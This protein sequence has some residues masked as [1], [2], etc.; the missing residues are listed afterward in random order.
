MKIIDISENYSKS[1]LDCKKCPEYLCKVYQERILNEQRFY[2]LASRDFTLF[3]PCRVINAECKGNT[4]DEKFQVRLCA[5]DSP[6][7][8]I[9][10]GTLHEAI[11]MLLN[12]KNI[13]LE[14]AIRLTRIKNEI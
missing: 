3:P 14:D 9:E 11:D 1:P 4:A 13:Q 8:V 5:N 7:E 2:L 12:N 6:W 10:Q